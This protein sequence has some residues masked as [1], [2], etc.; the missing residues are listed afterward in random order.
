MFSL[1]P[2][3]GESCSVVSD[4]L[5]PHGLYRPHGILQARILECVAVL[6]GAFP[7]QGLNPGL[8]HCR[9]TLYQL[10]HHRSPRT[11]EWVVYPFSGRSSWPRNQTGFPALQSDSLPAELPGKPPKSSSHSVMSDSLR[12]PIVHGILQARIL[13]WVAVPFSR[14]SSQPRDWTQVIHS[15]SHQG[16][17]RILEWVAYP[18][19][20]RSSQPRNQTGVSYIA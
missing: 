15:L 12:P 18:F 13:V 8:P 7:N 6:Q 17:P 4:S 11:L 5:R 20:S 14:R 2:R 3:E 16:S 19:S 9:W 1:Y 10:S